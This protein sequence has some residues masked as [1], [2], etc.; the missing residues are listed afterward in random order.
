M[1][2]SLVVLVAVSIGLGCTCADQKPDE[3]GKKPTA[4]TEQQL[5][6]AKEAFARIGGTCS[7]LEKDP[8]FHMPLHTVD[9]DLKKIPNLSF[10]SGLG[11]GGTKVTDGGL[12]EIANLKNLT[13]LYLDSTKVTDAG[14]KEIAKLKNLT[15]LRLS[16]TKVT[17]AGLK[18]IAKLKKLTSLRPLLA[19]R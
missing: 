5:E 7:F 4:P 11:L 2:E 15:F 10:S 19:P 9:E 18:E 14:L 3:S 6:A 1:K 16:E 17:D 13:Y 8:I 12:K